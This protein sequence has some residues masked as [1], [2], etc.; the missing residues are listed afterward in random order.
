MRQHDLGSG[1]FFTPDDDNERRRVVILGRNVADTLFDN[2]SDAVGQRITLDGVTFEV[3]AVLTDAWNARSGNSFFDPL[4]EI[5]IP[6]QTGRSRLFRNAINSQ[7]DIDLMSIKATQVDQVDLAIEQVTAILRERHELDPEQQNG[8]SIDNPRE[9]AEQSAAID[10]GLNA[11]LMVVASISLFVGGVGVMNIMLVSVAQRSSEIGLRKAVGARQSDILFQFLV[12]AV[13]ICLI[14]C[15][16]GIAFGYGLSYIGT[17]L[18]TNGLEL[19][20]ARAVVSGGSILLATLVSTLTGIVF[21]FFP[22]WRAARLHPIEA[23][24]IE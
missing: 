3:I 16:V 19:D 5:Y 4:R 6:Y 17:W 2:P 1:R 9:A 23:L 8:F 12:E 22:A 24:R 10:Q 14:G 18:L 15:A 20:G 7:V 21:G 11:F 13:V